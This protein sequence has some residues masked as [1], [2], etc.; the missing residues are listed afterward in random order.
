MYTNGS[1]YIVAG[2]GGVAAVIH[3]STFNHGC[4]AAAYFNKLILQFFGFVSIFCNNITHPPNNHYKHYLIHFR[5]FS[6]AEQTKCITRYQ[7]L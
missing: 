2:G 1:N 4:T 3:I 5:F 6:Q 7:L